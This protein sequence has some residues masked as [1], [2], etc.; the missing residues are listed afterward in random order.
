MSKL[1]KLEALRHLKNLER[2][3]LNRECDWMDAWAQPDVDGNYQNM[4]QL[5]TVARRAFFAICEDIQRLQDQIDALHETVAR[6]AFFAICEDVQ[7][8]QDQIDALHEGGSISLPPD[9]QD[10]TATVVNG[11]WICHCPGGHPDYR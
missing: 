1:E 8:L 10:E 5:V 3:R 4:P 7:R 9:C 2:A 6:R 11:K